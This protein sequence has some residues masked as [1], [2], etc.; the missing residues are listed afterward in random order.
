MPAAA[1]A[2]YNRIDIGI[3]LCMLEICMA[4]ESIGFSRELFIDNGKENDEYSKVA[5]YTLK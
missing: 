3:Y 1:V 4:K 5:E 2:Y